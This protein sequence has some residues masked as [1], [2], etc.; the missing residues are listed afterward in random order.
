LRFSIPTRDHNNILLLIHR[1][2]GNSE[3]FAS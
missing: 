2:S 1:K 3:K